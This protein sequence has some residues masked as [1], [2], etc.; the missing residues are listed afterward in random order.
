M[1][2][3]RPEISRGALDARLPKATGQRPDPGFSLVELLAV[4]AILAVLAS[5]AL[6]LAELSHQRTNE[7][8]LRRSLRE[9]R[10][11]KIGRAHV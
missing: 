1:T 3:S 4:V 9:I 10:T 2:A 6:P 11:A 8:D 5:I 7:E